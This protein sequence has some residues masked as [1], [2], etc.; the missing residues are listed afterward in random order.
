MTAMPE[1]SIKQLGEQ[2]AQALEIGARLERGPSQRL[3]DSAFRRELEA[4][5]PLFDAL[6]RVD[7]AHTLALI[8]NNIVP[9]RDGQ[10]LLA[11]LLLLKQH[12]AD[13]QPQA[14]HGDIYTNR[15]AW[16]AEHTQAAGWLG[17]GRAR[18]E[19]IT[20]AYTIKL[21]ELLLNLAEAL[22]NYLETLLERSAQA[23]MLL[24]PDYTYLQSAQPTSFGHYLLGFAYP[25]LRDLERLQALYARL[26][27]SPAG[28]G[29]NNGS[30]IPQ[31][32]R[33]L[34]EL[35]GFDGLVIHARDAMWQADLPIETAAVLSAIMINLDRLA[36]DLQILATDEFGLLEL[37]DRHARASKIMPQKKNPFALT[38]IRGV[39]NAIV[40]LLAGSAAMGRTP[41]GQPDNRLQLYGLLPQSTVDVTDAIAL[42]GEVVA[43][44]TFNHRLALSKL[45]HDFCLATD[46]AEVLVLKT[47]LSFRAAHKL[48]GTL[49]KR[50]LPNGNFNA[51]STADIEACAGELLGKR[52]KLEHDDLRQALDPAAAIAARNETGCAAGDSMVEMLEQ[53]RQILHHSRQWHSKQIQRL[54]AAE[55]ELERAVRQHLDSAP[56]T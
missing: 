50:H 29:S 40:G 52:I 32:R 6:S 49:V 34:A 7:L 8:E 25:A 9:P 39:A 36:E 3:I 11:G 24:M 22:H 44:L 47:G 5:L 27:S 38:H 45:D 28:C 30:R 48:V 46:L 42:M 41:T 19:A 55:Q 23:K 15:E 33:R 10:D 51:L 35:L 18:R 14:A 4:Q 1:Y 31:S 53:C 17:T 56:S 2:A 21:R 16:L 54:A 20:T 12:P 37:D 26:N 13:F 43:C